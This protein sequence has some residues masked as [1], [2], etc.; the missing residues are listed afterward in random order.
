METT[1]KDHIFTEIYIGIHCMMVLMVLIYYVYSQKIEWMMTLALVIYG[2]YLGFELYLFAS[3]QIFKLENKLGGYFQSMINIFFIFICSICLDGF[4]FSTLPIYCLFI[5]TASLANRR[6]K[7]IIHGLLSTL[8]Y[9]A[10]GIMNHYFSL[11]VVLF[12][13]M[14]LV[15][16][17][18]FVGE[19][20]QLISDVYKRNYFAMEEIEYRISCWN[21]GLPLI[22]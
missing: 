7:S 2:S 19:L 18:Y 14:L 11:G 3:R 22:S 1:H 8:A 6:T 21:T 4:S 10:A 9:V 5:L 20:N 13:G 15:A 16:Y 12:Q 17:S